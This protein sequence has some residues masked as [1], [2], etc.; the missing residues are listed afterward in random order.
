MYGLIIS[1]AF[2]EAFR[3]VSVFHVHSYKD[4]SGSHAVS[5]GAV[6]QSQTLSLALLL[7]HGKKSSPAE[8]AALSYSFYCLK[9]SYM[10]FSPHSQG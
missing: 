10:K 8:E 5:L 4:G 7:V 3:G 1:Q 6:E 2:D 9:D